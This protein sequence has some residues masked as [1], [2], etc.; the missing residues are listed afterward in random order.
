MHFALHP[1]ATQKI[2]AQIC[3]AYLLQLKKHTNKVKQGMVEG[4]PLAQ[5]SAQSWFHHYKH[6]ENTMDPQLSRQIL[7]LFQDQEVFDSWT[8]LHDIDRLWEF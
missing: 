5:Y 2:M 3:V 1:G 8:S 6:T 7:E 4:F